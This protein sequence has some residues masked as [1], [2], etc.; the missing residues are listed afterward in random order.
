LYHFYGGETKLSDEILS[1]HDAT[2][3]IYENGGQLLSS[4]NFK[5]GK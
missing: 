1:T 5:N 3:I 2:L 4:E